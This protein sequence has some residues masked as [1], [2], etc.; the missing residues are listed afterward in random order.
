VGGVAA[1]DARLRWRRRPA[2]RTALSGAVEGDRDE[3]RSLTSGSGS[4]CRLH[5]S[6]ACPVGGSRSDRI[7]E[8]ENRVSGPRR[9]LPGTG[10]AGV[11]QISVWAGLEICARGHPRRAKTCR[12]PISSGPKHSAQAA[13]RSGTVAP[14]CDSAASQPETPGWVRPPPVATRGS[15]GW[16]GGPQKQPGA[17]GRHIHPVATRGRRRLV[18]PAGG[19]QR[20]PGSWRPDHGRIQRGLSPLFRHGGGEELAPCARA[21]LRPFGMRR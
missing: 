4:R 10:A 11:R 12:K 20:T 14:Q 1:T 5:H 7:S 9:I 15:V 21:R 17:G 2:A 6:A 18:R 16:R 3:P 19:P 13:R 8:G